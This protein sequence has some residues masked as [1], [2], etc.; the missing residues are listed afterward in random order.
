[1]VARENSIEMQEP[2][3]KPREEPRSE[4]WPVLFWLCRVEIIAVHGQDVQTFLDD[5]QG[6]IIIIFTVIEEV[7][8][9]QHL[10][11]KCQ[12][13]FHSQAFRVRD[14]RCC[15]E[16]ESR[17][18]QVRDKVARLVN[19][20]G[21]HSRRQNSYNWSSCT[22]RWTGDSKEAPGQVVPGLRSTGRGEREN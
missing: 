2:R 8:T 14:S 4:G 19:R 1:M 15:S 5:Q 20:S 9:G 22:T 18:Q 12:L 6:Q 13:A 17:K 10:G 11:S 3:K 21:F 16:R 7:V